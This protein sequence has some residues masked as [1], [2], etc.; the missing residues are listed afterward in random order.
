[1]SKILSQGA[2]T[3]VAFALLL[4]T[5]IATA[6]SRNAAFP[7]LL[8]VA[9]LLVVTVALQSEGTK[10]LIDVA[11]WMFSFKLDAPAA[12]IALAIILFALVSLLW[13]PAPGRGLGALAGASTAALVSVYCCALLARHISIPDWLIWALPLTIAVGCF[14]LVSELMFGSPVRSALGAFPHFSR[15]NRAALTIA[16]MLPL[17]FLIG[18]NRS[19]IITCAAVW[20]MALAVVLMSAS[21]T[22]KIIIIVSIVTLV[23][24]RFIQARY[25][26]FFVGMFVIATHAFAPLVLTALYSFFPRDF[27]EAN[28]SSLAQHFVRLEIWWAYAQQ[29]FAAPVIGHGLQASYNAIDAYAGS[30]EGIIRGLVF[31]HPHNFSIQVWYELGMLGVTLSST[32]IFLLLRFILKLPD[33]QL[34]VAVMQVIGVWSVAYVSHGAWQHWWWALI[35][36]ITILFSSLRNQSSRSI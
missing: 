25:L 32:M 3:N 11:R 12:A 22:A 35:G 36:I 20:P 1:L 4:A 9:L 8:V 7:L 16:L 28:A 6:L 30:D 24:A 23:I 19:R 17:L 34:K 33:I 15:L 5:P 13:S 26:L 2:L 29:V 31:I 27:I 18:D 14:L 21:E 10:K